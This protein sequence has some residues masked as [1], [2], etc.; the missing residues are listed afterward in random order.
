[1]EER[2]EGSQPGE[3]QTGMGNLKRDYI[4]RNLSLDALSVAD[5]CADTI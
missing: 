2:K 1:M 3:G 4:V 5:V